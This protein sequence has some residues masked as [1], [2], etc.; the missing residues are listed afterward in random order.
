MGREK[1]LNNIGEESQDEEKNSVEKNLGTLAGSE[2]STGQLCN[3][4]ILRTNSI[5]GSVNRV[6]I[7]KPRK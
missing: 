2:L 1:I 5:L 4:Q 3:V 6:T 7:R